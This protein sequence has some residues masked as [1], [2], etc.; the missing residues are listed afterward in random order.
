MQKLVNFLEKNVQWV[1]LG[2][3]VVVSAVGTVVMN[4]LKS[5]Q[6]GDTICAVVGEKRQFAPGVLTRPMNSKAMPDVQE[7]ADAVVRSANRSLVLVSGGSRAGDEAMLD[8]ARQSMQAGATGLIFGRNVWQRQHT[9]S[10]KLAARL[11]SVL[12]QFPST[13]RAP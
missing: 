13:L 1:A 5:G 12:E 7:A 6:H 8:K 9:E 4:R 11:R 2:L 3:A 10:L